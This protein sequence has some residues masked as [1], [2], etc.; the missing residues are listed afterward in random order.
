MVGKP[1]L[2]REERLGQLCCLPALPF[3]LYDEGSLKLLAARF[4]PRDGILDVGSRLV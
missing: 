1:N 3:S 2:V 4:A